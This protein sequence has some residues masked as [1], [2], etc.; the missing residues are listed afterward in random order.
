MAH[1]SRD[2]VGRHLTNG[3]A[4]IVQVAMIVGFAG[5]REGKGGE[6]QDACEYLCDVGVYLVV[7]VIPPIC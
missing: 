3:M 1:F 4:W 7:G 5:D 2:S 6:V